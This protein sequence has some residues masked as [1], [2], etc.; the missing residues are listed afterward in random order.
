[1]IFTHIDNI[2]V[3]TMA[4]VSQHAVAKYSHALDAV[5]SFTPNCIEVVCPRLD[6]HAERAAVPWQ[7]QQLSEDVD[8]L[9]SQCIVCSLCTS[10]RLLE[11]ID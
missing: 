10:T 2:V 9:Y 5:T 8:V 7:S 11:Y 3:T 4:K 1:M 6:E